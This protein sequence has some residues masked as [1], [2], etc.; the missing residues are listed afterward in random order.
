MKLT[1]SGGNTFRSKES[2]LKQLSDYHSELVQALASKDDE[3][4]EWMRDKSKMSSALSE[5]QNKCKTLDAL[6]GSA[7]EDRDKL[8]EKK[9][10]LESKVAHLS[11]VTKE[12][13][14][15]LRSKEEES[16]ELSV[17]NSDL[18]K[19][20]FTWMCSVFALRSYRF[21]LFC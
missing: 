10:R 13:A 12:V 8:Q 7:V 11:A 19:E 1:S 9:D 20:T 4:L 17:T 2:Q 6:L 15:R 18:G 5:A 3:R 21:A 16:L 14:T